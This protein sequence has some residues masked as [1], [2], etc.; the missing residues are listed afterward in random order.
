MRV[1]APRAGRSRPAAAP[2]PV[3]GVNSIRGIHQ[4]CRTMAHPTLLLAFVW[5]CPDTTDYGDTATPR[6][7][8]PPNLG[9][10]SP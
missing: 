6:E 9:E 5:R 4:L 3:G 7:Y 2:S 10:P 1:A 8:A